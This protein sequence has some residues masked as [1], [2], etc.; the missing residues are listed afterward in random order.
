MRGL[1]LAVHPVHPILTDFPIA[2][3]TTAV[4][5]DVVALVTGAAPIPPG[6]DQAED[7]RR[8]G[9]AVLPRTPRPITA[10]VK[11]LDRPVHPP[12]AVAVP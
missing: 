11:P 9:R 6:A 4:L 10:N 2:L 1:R 5:W 3:L 12:G 7:P 8:A